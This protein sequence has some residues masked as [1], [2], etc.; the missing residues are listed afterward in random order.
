MPRRRSAPSLAA[1]AALACLLFVVG[2]AG[3]WML[4]ARDFA[5]LT[6]IKPRPNATAGEGAAS[7]G[8]APPSGAGMLV[9]ELGD[10]VTC[11]YRPFDNVTGWMGSDSYAECAHSLRQRTGGPRPFT[12]GRQ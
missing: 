7:A 12:W 4:G 6:A 9:F 5:A 11:R 10:G 2:L 3:A 8:A 1:P